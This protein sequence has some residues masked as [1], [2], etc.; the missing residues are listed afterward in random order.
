LPPFSE[1][2][3]SIRD[4]RVASRVG[5]GS[6]FVYSNDV[7]Q[8]SPDGRLHPLPGVG[9]DSGRA[10]RS[11]VESSRH[12][13]HAH[14]SRCFSQPIQHTIAG[15]HSSRPWSRATS[16]DTGT[17]QPHEASPR[18]VHS[19]SRAGVGFPARP[20]D[21]RVYFG[22]QRHHSDMA[23]SRENRR[24]SNHRHPDRVQGSDDEGDVGGVDMWTE[25][26]AT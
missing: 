10:S 21:R 19:L 2:M 17:L 26:F 9:E 22:T 16:L 6:Y 8:G 4:R 5:Q 1:L 14:T 7:A 23:V 12:P 18:S 20:L 11:V 3:H 13:S 15:S 25:A 24:M